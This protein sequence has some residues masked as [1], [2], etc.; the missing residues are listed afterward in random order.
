MAKPTAVIIIPTY[1]EKENIKPTTEAILSVF[2]NIKAY[3]MHILFVDDNSPDNTK[4]EIKKFQKDHKN[5][6][7]FL[8]EKKA[9]LGNAYKK[10][11]TYALE[12][13]DANIIFQ[14]DA[15]LS[16]D[17]KLLP[18]ML[19]KLEEYDIVLGSR[20]IPGGSIPQNWG[21]SR[22]LLSTLGNKV[23]RLILGNNSVKDWTTGYRA[24]KKPAAEFIL[25]NID[26]QAFSG[27]TYQVGSL[28]KAIERGFKV[29]ELPLEFKDRTRGY[30]KLGFEYLMNT[31]V[32]IMKAR[33]EKLLKIREIRFV[34]VG[35]TAALIQLITLTIYRLALP[36][37]LAF[38]LAIESAV[39]WNFIW[40]NFWTFKDRKLKL[41]QVPSKFIQFNLASGGSILIQQTIAFIGENTIGLVPLFTVPIINFLVDTGTMYAVVG[42]LV[43][44]FWN[45]FAYNKFIWKKKKK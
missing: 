4:K 19:E 44:M 27:Y 30:S 36:Y 20:Y 42:I 6:H 41:K 18:Q 2:Q 25:D 39:V 34:I 37:Q 15:D 13:L 26:S 8:N 3:D 40:S 43:G 17:P 12:E 31:M 38:F 14:F 9:G 23:I 29:A 7:L 16:H 10:G 1:N 45:F 5:I 11:I 35:G 28:H 24:I 33:I 21:F 22:K 32:Y